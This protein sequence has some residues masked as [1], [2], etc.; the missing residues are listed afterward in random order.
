V[1]ALHDDFR[2]PTARPHHRRISTYALSVGSIVE[3]EQ[4]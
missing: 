4:I 2:S 3:G 1:A